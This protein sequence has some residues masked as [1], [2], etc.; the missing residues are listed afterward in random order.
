MA[1]AI[2]FCAVMTMR[3]VS[4]PSS[5]ARVRRSRPETS[6][7]RMSTRATS[8][9]LV[10]SVSSAALPVPTPI[11][12]W[13]RWPRDRS[14]TQRIDSSSS[15]TRRVPPALV[16]SALMRFTHGQ[17]DAEAG[18]ARVRGFVDDRA[19]VL[20]DDAL[21]ERQSETATA[22]LRREE[23]REEAGTIG[24]RHAGAVVG[25]GHDQDALV[26]APAADAIAGVHPRGDGDRALALQRFERVLH[27]VQEHLM[28]LRGVGVDRRQAGVE[29]RDENRS[30]PFGGLPLQVDDVLQ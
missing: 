1:F 30:A 7:M 5:F 18:A 13:P 23:R 28:E 22:R 4:M 26:A 20:H 15:A 29:L 9:S 10:R 6:G 25:D 19:A 21:A 12:R 16:V 8:T 11:T 2:V 3:S 27:Q 24:L 14:R 17:G